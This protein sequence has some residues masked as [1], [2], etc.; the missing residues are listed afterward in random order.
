MW[1]YVCDVYKAPHDSD[2][3]SFSLHQWADMSYSPLFID[4]NTKRRLNDL[5]TLAEL[6]TFCNKNNTATECESK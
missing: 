2:K 3:V 4:I 6:T 1:F 5:T